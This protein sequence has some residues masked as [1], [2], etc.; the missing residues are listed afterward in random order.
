MEKNFKNQEMVER[1]I[2]LIM[3]FLQQ[4]FSAPLPFCKVFSISVESQEAAGSTF[5]S[6]VSNWHHRQQSHD[7]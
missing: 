3:Y 6:S 5:V 4:D 7:S 2:F 1:L